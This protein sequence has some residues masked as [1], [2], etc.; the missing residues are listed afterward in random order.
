M[1][2]NPFRR[3]TKPHQ[4]GKKHRLYPGDRYDQHIGLVGL[5][6]AGKTVFLT[7]LIDHI[8]LNGFSSRR[9]ISLTNFR[10][11]DVDHRSGQAFP[12]K[13]FRQKIA[14][15][16]IWPPKT[17]HVLNYACEFRRSDWKLPIRLHFYDLP[18]ERIADAAMY[19]NQYVEWSKHTLK[20]L[21]QNIE[22]EAELAGYEE[23][24]K[25]PDADAHA[26]LEKYKHIL[27]K[28]INAYGALITPSTFILGL[29]GKKID[30]ESTNH[31]NLDRPLGIDQN[32]QFA[33]L[34]AIVI[35]QRP[36]LAK[37]FESAYKAYK[38]K[39]VDPVFSQLRKCQQLL[40][41]VD[42]IGLLRESVD[43]YNDASTLVTDLINSCDPHN[44]KWGEI[45][46]WILPHRFARR[47]V[48][49]VCLIG[50]KMDMALS[51]DIK[52]SKMNALLKEMAGSQ[53]NNLRTY[54]VDH[55]ILTCA[56]VISMADGSTS[57]SRKGYFVFDE[58]GTP[59]APPAKGQV[60]TECEVSALP[61]SW[62]EHWAQGEFIFPDVYPNV[63][64]NMRKPPLQEGLWDIFE[65]ICGSKDYDN[66]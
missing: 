49:R 51:V 65:F 63:P 40:I 55:N 18:G 62:P 30:L 64:E 17:G 25:S 60:K 56:S 3:S 6:N 50:T 48:K 29:D 15:N 28:L 12:Q 22:A 47:R 57:K 44:P 11:L 46:D 36:E 45:L 10:E 27:L 24:C 54:G 59:C 5:G 32:N 52:E 41:L 23:L 8:Q 14:R 4:A 37:Q 42:V 16:H 38:T 33:P 58:N 21:S 9:G 26:I 7:S 20:E 35:K 1:K 66:A 19:P 2:L 61:D 31:C 34:P 53:L 43:A 13:L 39:V